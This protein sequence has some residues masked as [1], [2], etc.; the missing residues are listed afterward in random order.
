MA[1]T[2][3]PP[4]LKQQYLEAFDRESETTLKVMRAYPAEQS[5]LR[6]HPTS[7]SAR[8]VCWL[9]V[10]EMG[11]AAAAIT[12][13]MPVPPPAPPPPPA[14]LG[15]VIGAYEQA[16]KDYRAL[17]ESTAEDALL[18]T[19]RFYVGP[20]TLGDVP[21]LQFMWI[22]LNDSIHHRGQ[23]SVYLR[24]TGSKVPSIY[25]PSRDEPWF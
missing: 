13:T 5:E 11:A 20:K 24:M 2:A 16:R 17:V 9:F 8:E 3:A 1:M 23:L 10:A 18:A 4:G 14:T 25:G 6:P 12:D 22:M 19:F 21:R 15:E 7:M